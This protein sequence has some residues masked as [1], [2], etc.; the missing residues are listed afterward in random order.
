MNTTDLYDL[1]RE[2]VVD[3]AKPYL[4]SDREV[5]SYMDDAQK[6]FSRLGVGIG[7]VTT[8]AVVE[9][10]IVVGQEYSPIHKSI[11]T[12]RQAR[13]KSTN[14]E[15]ALKNLLDAGSA[16]YD[17]YG[18][19]FC[20]STEHRPGP[21]RGMVIG[22]EYNKVRWVGIPQEADT[23]VIAVCRLPL[24]TIT[25]DSEGIE[26][27]IREEHQRT[28]LYWMKSLAYSKQDAETFDRAKAVDNENKFYS[29]CEKAKREWERYKHKPRTIMYG[30]IGGIGDDGLPSSV[31]RY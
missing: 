17:D 15:I 16:N 18:N 21:V 28:L 7:D 29:A 1:F 31:R 12:I 10:P 3:L 13:L 11:L 30:G 5:F 4:W 27:E 24:Q 8:T 20:S 6:M 14:R 2:D 23:A 26:F 25:E 19:I 9:V 22:E